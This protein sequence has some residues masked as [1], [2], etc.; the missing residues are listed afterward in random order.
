[1]SYSISIFSFYFDSISLNLLIET[2]LARLCSMN[3]IIKVSISYLLSI[4]HLV[5]KTDSATV[6][7][8]LRFLDTP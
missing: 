4:F 8:A 7:M 1:M 5:A 3:G 2:K 6:L